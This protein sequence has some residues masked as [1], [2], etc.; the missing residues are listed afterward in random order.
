MTKRHIAIRISDS[1]LALI[2]QHART[3][4]LDRTAYLVRAGR[5]ELDEAGFHQRLD[6]LEQR[7]VDLERAANLGAF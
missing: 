4:G 3:L 6:G 7:I 2:D 5:Q 1:D